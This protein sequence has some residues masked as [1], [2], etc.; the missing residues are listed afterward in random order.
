MVMDARSEITRLNDLIDHLCAEVKARLPWEEWV[1]VE[2]AVYAFWTT[3]VW[4]VPEAGSIS[5]EDK[6]KPKWQPREEQKR[7]QVA[8][9]THAVTREWVHEWCATSPA[10]WTRAQLK[11]LGVGWPPRRGWLSELIGTEIAG[12]KAREFERLSG[13]LVT[14]RDVPCELSDMSSKGAACS[15][16]PCASTTRANEAPA[17]LEGAGDGSAHLARYREA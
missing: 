4:I 3:G 14:G 12:E 13:R 17:G 10:G 5:H 11:L 2:V 6:P 8:T 16:P 1:R 7:E 15:A 9:A